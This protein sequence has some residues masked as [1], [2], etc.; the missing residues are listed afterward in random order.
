MPEVSKH[1][2]KALA[3]FMRILLSSRFSSA[4]TM[5]TVSLSRARVL[6][7]SLTT[8]K[9]A[10]KLNWI[11]LI[12][13][14][15]ENIQIWVVHGWLKILMYNY[16]TITNH[17]LV[18]AL[19]ALDQHIVPTE[20]VQLLQVDASHHVRSDQ[21]LEILDPL[22]ISHSRS[23]SWNHNVAGGVRCLLCAQKKSS[24]LIAESECSW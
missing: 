24:E 5:Q 6:N 20:E 22:V 2:T 12:D 3:L 11:I 15:G 7:S 21:A 14:L 23:N 17:P 4:R 8:Q 1:T 9:A 16:N 13:P 18:L 10:F 19:L